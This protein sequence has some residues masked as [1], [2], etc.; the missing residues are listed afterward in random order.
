MKVL[1]IGLG[2]IAKK[3]IVAL[4]EIDASVEIIA[5]RSSKDA[6]CVENI[7][8]V[9]DWK[10]VALERPD[11][12]LVSNPTALHF[13]TLKETKIYPYLCLLKTLVL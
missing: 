3:H 1:I 2:S 10:S 11:F 9:Y 8:N 5:L 4:R 7:R 6:P 13:E 12:I